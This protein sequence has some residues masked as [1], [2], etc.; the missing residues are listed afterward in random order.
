[1]SNKIPSEAFQEI[2]PI[3]VTGIVEEVPQKG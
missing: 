1:M 2:G 3:N